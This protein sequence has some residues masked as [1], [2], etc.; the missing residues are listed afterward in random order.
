VFDIKGRRGLLNWSV[1][2]I[3]HKEEKDE[4]GNSKR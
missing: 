1:C 4:K 2:G 3:L